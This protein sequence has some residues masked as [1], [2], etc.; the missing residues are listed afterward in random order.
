MPNSSMRQSPGDRARRRRTGLCRWRLGC[1]TS[2]G[3]GAPQFLSPQDVVGDAI[4][5]SDNLDRSRHLP[6]FPLSVVTSSR[7]AENRNTHR[8][9]SATTRGF[10]PRGLSYAKRR[11]ETLHETG[12]AG[13][14]CPTATS[15]RSFMGTAN[16]SR[17][18]QAAVARPLRLQPESTQSDPSGHSS[19]LPC[20]F[21]RRAPDVREP[22]PTDSLP[23]G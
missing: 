12:T 15:R 13:L 6:R 16:G 10:V 23:K 20:R 17:R 22:A 19:I 1:S 21:N 18:A 9:S 8:P 2:I 4:R 3:A 11:S 14:G 5:S 7:S